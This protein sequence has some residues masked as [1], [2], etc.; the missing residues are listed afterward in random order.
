LYVT[1]GDGTSDSDTNVTGQRTDLLL[2]KVLRIDVDHVGEPS[3]VRPRRNYSI[4]GDNPYVDD[5]RFAPETWAYGLRHPWRMCSD[6]K[7]GHIWVGQNGQDLWETA[8]L[9]RKGANYGWSVMEGSHPFYRERKS[10]PTPIVKPTVEHHHS[11]SRSLTG[12]VVYYG[13]RYPDLQG[14]YLYG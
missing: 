11:E 2:A 10:G 9:V 8:M 6:P 5:K 1:S 12:G 7:T 3:G 14:A 4:P 13:E